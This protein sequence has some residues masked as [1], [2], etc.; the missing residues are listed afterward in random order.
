[1]H[2][3]RAYFAFSRFKNG[4]DQVASAP[5][6]FN[7]TI[8]CCAGKAILVACAYSA[9]VAVAYTDGLIRSDNSGKHVINL[10]VAVFECESTGNDER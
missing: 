10:H 1:M 2:V 4:F 5:L 8:C 7:W 9:R 3:A 6:M